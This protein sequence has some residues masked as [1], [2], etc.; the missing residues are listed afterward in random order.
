VLA[1]RAWREGDVQAVVDEFQAERIAEEHD[2][3][4]GVLVGGIGDIAFS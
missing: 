2:R 4:L 1:S 3:V